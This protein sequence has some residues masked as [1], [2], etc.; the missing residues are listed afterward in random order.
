MGV[1]KAS[2]MSQQQPP[3]EELQKQF[4]EFMEEKMMKEE[5]RTKLRAMP[6]SA[7]WTLICQE[8][9][10]QREDNAGTPQ[11]WAAKL[12]VPAGQLKLAEI[13]QLRVLIRSKG[14]TWVLQF[15]EAG[16]LTAVQAAISQER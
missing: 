15:V 13:Q 3:E 4:E 7:K 8:R 16:G 6:S 12:Q 9:Q 11:E 2:P 5:V 1:E 10:A 14:R